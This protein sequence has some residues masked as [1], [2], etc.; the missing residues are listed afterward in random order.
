[1]SKVRPIPEGYRSVTA[2]LCLEGADRAIAFY[3][4][5]FGATER[6]RLAT[7]EGRSRTRRSRSATRSSC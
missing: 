5:A 4:E 1:M 3:E 2:F 6:M 7:A